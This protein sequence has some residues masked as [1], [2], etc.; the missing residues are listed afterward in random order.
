MPY[1]K[2]FLT[3]RMPNTRTLLV[4]DH[5]LA[6]AGVRALI[7]SLPNYDVVAECADGQTAIDAVRQHKPDLVLLDLMMPD[8]SG[9]EVMQNI[10]QFDTSAR[11]LVLSV[12]DRREVVDQ[13]LAAGANG[14]LLKDFILSELKDAL[15]T[16]A[17][18]GCFISPRLPLEEKREADEADQIQLTARQLEILKFV[19]SGLTTKGIAKELG[20]SPK[21]VEFHRSQLME[22][23][24]VRDVAGLTRYALQRGLLE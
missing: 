9:I 6:R 1:P 17:E 15:Q 7:E 23:I 14:Y 11:I 18:D 16:V 8:I 21:T 22:R 19:A 20:I 12:V 4:D 10:R 24:G 5:L 2:S 3:L 13:A